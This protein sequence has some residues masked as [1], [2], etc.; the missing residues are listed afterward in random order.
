MI[1]SNPLKP[2]PAKNIKILNISIV[3]AKPQAKTEPP[4]IDNDSKM[5]FLRPI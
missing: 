2:K 5:V 3:I 4:A 1:V